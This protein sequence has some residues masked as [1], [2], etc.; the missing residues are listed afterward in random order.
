MRGALRS[1]STSRHR[2]SEDA[3]RRAAAIPW[4]PVTHGPGL[5]RSRWVG[6][7]TEP[8]LT[9]STPQ[10][11]GNTDAGAVFPL[12]QDGSV[13]LLR[14]GGQLSYADRRFKPLNNNRFEMPCAARRRRSVP[15]LNPATMA[16]MQ[17]CG[18]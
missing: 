13:D 4:L 5:L 6:P 16:R 2:R 18:A 15:P 14:V 17:R 8:T 11:R 1:D 3:R 7:Y 12:A 9:R 10:V